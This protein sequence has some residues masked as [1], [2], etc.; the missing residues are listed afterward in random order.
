MRPRRDR[1]ARLLATTAALAVLTGAAACTSGGAPATG[2]GPAASGTQAEVDPVAGDRAQERSAQLVTAEEKRIYA[3]SALEPGD[4]PAYVA[5]AV[6]PST[7]STVVLTARPLPYRLESL[8]NLGAATRRAD[9]GWD[10]LMSV[11]VERGATL[12]VE[13]PGTQLRMVSGPA[14]F[15]SI[16]AVK[17]TLEMVGEQGR[18]LEVTSWD[19][20][21]G[22]ADEDTTDGRAYLRTAGGRLDLTDVSASSLGFWSG[23]TGGISWTGSNS[24]PSTGTALRTA[25]QRSHF[26]MFAARTDGLVIDSGSLRDNELD[27]LLVHRRS[28]GITV[29][30]T[31]MVHNGRNGVTV[32][33]GASQVTLSGITVHDN[34]VDG[35]RIDGTPRTDPA[36]ADPNAAPGH[37]F[38]VERSVLDGNGESGIVANAAAELTLVDNNVVGSPDGIVVSGAAA[39]QEVRGNTV[40]ARG[41]GIAVRNGATEAQLTGNT[42]RTATIALQVSDARADLRQNVVGAAHRYAVSLTGSSG[43]ST[44]SGNRL[45]GRGPAAIDTVR[46]RSGTAVQVGPNDDSGWVVD[47]DETGRYLAYVADHPLLLLW[48]L[49]LVVPVAAG[50][51]T[52]RRRQVPAAVADED[53]PEDPMRT[54]PLPV[55]RRRDTEATFAMPVTRVTIVSEPDR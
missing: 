8:A 43:G 6:A 12:H 23:R 26:G 15:T 1:R 33:A 5:P 54:T 19:P 47:R 44:V 48:L 4:H 2:A 21:S 17:G 20:V 53:E 37:A 38:T 31:E 55:V 40:E 46:V 45:G 52:R 32:A 36:G 28:N 11:V 30:G 22:H 29:R 13:A 49:I 7:I 27:G 42:V 10:L 50:L 35:I 39:R 34:A 25:V 14:G 18:P 3:V 24:Q 16:V 41:F 9:G 51:W